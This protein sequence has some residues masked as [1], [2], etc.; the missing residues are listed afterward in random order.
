GAFCCVPGFHL[1][2][3]TWLQEQNKTDMELQQQHWD[4]WPIKPIAA[5][6]GDL[7]IWHHAL[8]HG[9]TPN[10][11]LLPRMVQYINFYP[12]AS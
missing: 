4:E 2:I 11:G 5:S 9:P 8:P 1:K 10:R 12:M 3:E 7:I 6:A